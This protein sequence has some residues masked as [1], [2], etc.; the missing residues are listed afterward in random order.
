MS[1]ED[2]SAGARKERKN[3]G[4]KG[5]HLVPPPKKGER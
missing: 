4:E 3:R 5:E 1:D 2:I